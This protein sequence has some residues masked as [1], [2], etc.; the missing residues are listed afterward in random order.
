[1]SF[2][3]EYTKY[4]FLCG[5]PTNETHHL[6][7]GGALRK[8][9]DDDDLFLPCCRNCHNEIHNN[10]TAGKMSKIIGQLAFELNENA[11]KGDIEH[12]REHFRQRYGRSY[13]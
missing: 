1:M 13:L 6:V 8:L 4:C 10:P 3:S 11:H 9:A 12:A 2:I 5:T 7:Y